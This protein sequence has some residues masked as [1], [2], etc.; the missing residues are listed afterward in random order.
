LIEWPE[1]VLSG[2]VEGYIKLDG[3]GKVGL[4]FTLSP[5]PWLLAIK[6]LKYFLYVL[7]TH[8]LSTRPEF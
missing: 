8:G 3:M 2:V 5:S 4:G 7:V 6:A 1:R